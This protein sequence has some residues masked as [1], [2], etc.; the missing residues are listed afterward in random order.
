MGSS[1]KND[2]IDIYFADVRKRFPRR[3]YVLKGIN[4]LIQCD[5]MDLQKYKEF[6][7]GYIYILT[8]IN[9]FSK[10]AY[11]V[12]LKTKT[13][14]EVTD[15]MSKILL[16]VFP[17]IRNI[18]VDQGKEFYNEKFKALMK[19]YH[20]NMYSVYSEIKASF[21]ERFHRTLRKMIVKE[22][23]YRNSPKWIDFLQDI[24]DKYNNT[25]HSVTKIEPSKVSFTNEKIILR[26]LS[27]KKKVKKKKPKFKVGDY[28]HIS[29]KKHV[30]EKGTFNFTPLV[31]QIREVVLEDDPITYR[32]KDTEDKCEPIKGTFYEQELKLAT[33]GLTYVVEKVIKEKK[34][35]KKPFL[36][37]KWLGFD[38]QKWNSWIPKEN[39][40]Q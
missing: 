10:F 28:V 16:N 33:H 13:S 17:M 36:F 22:T 23:Y 11:A 39:V 12:P 37:V 25:I 6:N 32:L 1:V 7:D 20:I 8:A 5:L 31:F 27:S 29:K 40:V 24:L 3:R 19:K 18:Q 38:D 2:L 9:C 21:V 26:R 34:V 15:A 30:F 14:K 4:D 35:R